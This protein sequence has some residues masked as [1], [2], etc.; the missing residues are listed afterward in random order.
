MQYETTSIRSMLGLRFRDATTEQPVTD[1]LHVTVRRDDGVGRPTR[2]VRTTSGAYVAQGLAGLR[3]HERSSVS[4]PEGSLSYRVS[5]RDRRRRF[6]PVLLRVDLPYRPAPSDNGLY[7]I[8][9]TPSDVEEDPPEPTCYLF[10]AVQRP[11]GVGQAVVYADLVKRGPEGLLPVPFAVLE[12][13]HLPPDRNSGDETNN[14]DGNEAPETD[15]M[16][17]GVADANGRVAVQFPLPP[18]PLEEL[19]EGSADEEEEENGGDGGPGNG[20]PGNGPPTDGGPPNDND[21]AGSSGGRPLSGRTWSLGVRVRYEPQAQVTPP[22]ADRPLL[23]SIFRQSQGRL[24]EK[25]GAPKKER[26][27]TLFYREPLVLT[28]EDLGGERSA[29]LIAPESDDSENDNS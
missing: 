22:G 7:P 2:A 28:T 27:V 19:E 20:P 14:G 3:G 10:S 26:E 15:R 18:M 24:F 29:L 16:W 25:T 9:E 5:V 4:V 1:A 21:D 12:V 11:V 17:Y 13:R 23:P 8:V 6:V